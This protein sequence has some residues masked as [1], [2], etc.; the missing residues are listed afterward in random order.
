MFLKSYLISN[1]YKKKTIDNLYQNIVHVSRNKNFYQKL[2]VPDTFD[3]RF[4]MLV[5]FSVVLFHTL[6]RFKPNGPIVSQSLFDKIFLDLD[7]SLRELGAGDAGVNIKIKSMVNSF[8]GRQKSYCKSFQSNDFFQL[9]KT[10]IRNVYRNVQFSNT[11]PH[12]LTNYC[13]KTLFLFNKEEESYFL[14][15]HM[16][17][18]DF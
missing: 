13:K 2:E 7:F 6:L 5:L 18:P 14:K 12:D 4:D 17:F 11:S 3:G 10:I 8:M 16:I 9:E 15:N 1:N